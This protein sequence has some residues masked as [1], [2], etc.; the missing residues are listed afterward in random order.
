M[1]SARLRVYHLDRQAGSISADRLEPETEPLLDRALGVYRSSVGRTRGDV[2]N[3]ARATLEGLRPDRVEPVV[4]LLDAAATY[5]WPGT[6]RAAE[7]RVRVFEAAA[8][9]HP[10]VDPPVAREVL[11]G[12]LGAAPDRLDQTVATLYADYPAFHQLTGFPADYTTGALRADYDLAQAQA[13]LYSATRVC[14]EAHAD[15]KHVLRY[16]RL[17][18]LLYRLESLPARRRGP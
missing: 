11:A 9:R 16:A 12:V 6:V 3:A 17:A 10:V 5:E 15:F 7:R 18:R 4:K 8:S 13:L 14:V 1:L 2:R